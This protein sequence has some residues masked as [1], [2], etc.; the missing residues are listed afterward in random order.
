M[1]MFKKTLTGVALSAAMV[2]SASAAVISVNGIFWDPDA[3]NDFA[4]TSNF[5][6][7]FQASVPADATTAVAISD[8]ISPVNFYLTGVGSFNTFNGANNVPNLPDPETTPAQ[9]APNTQ[10][11]YEFGGIRVV[12]GALAPNGVSVSYTLDLTHSY[13]NVWADAAKDYDDAANTDPLNLNKAIGGSLFLTGFFESLNLNV[14]FLNF[15]SPATLGGSSSGLI[16]VTGGNA[17][18][19]FN[20]NSKADVLGNVGDLTF[21]A[22]SQFNI[23]GGGSS[24]ISAVSTGEFQG[25]TKAVPEPATIALLGGALLGLAATRRRRS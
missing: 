6:Q 1:N 24:K 14:S 15:V 19:N 12:S 20:T 21:T 22:S 11:T 3:A 16:S 17:F 18:A 2:A 5:H 8:F 13:F 9:F 25:D 10:L 23:P 7:W 4:G